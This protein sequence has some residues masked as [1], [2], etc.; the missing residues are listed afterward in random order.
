[1]KFRVFQIRF[2]SPPQ[3]H[4]EPLSDG[5]VRTAPQN[6]MSIDAHWF[7]GTFFI[8]TALNSFSGATLDTPFL[9][10]IL[11][12]LSLSNSLRRLFSLRISFK[13]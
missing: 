13:I 5:R 4:G 12:I 1:M 2:G 6:W 7:L 10:Q 8:R 11:F 9:L 3:V